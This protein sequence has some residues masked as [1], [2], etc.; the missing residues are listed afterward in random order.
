M[1]RFLNIPLELR[2]LII[3]HVLFSPTSP[4]S[5]LHELNGREYYDLNY[6]AWVSSG[7]RVYYTQHDIPSSPKC[8]SLLLINHQLSTET[9]A[10]LDRGKLHYIIDIAVKN[11]LDLL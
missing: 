2:E 3:E 6:S 11:E 9:R 5:T 1:S 4:P 10:V 7:A 8:L